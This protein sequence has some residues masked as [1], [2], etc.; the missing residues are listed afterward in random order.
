MGTATVLYIPAAPFE[1]WLTETF[2][3]VPAG[4]EGSYLDRGAIVAELLRRG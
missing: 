1:D 4:T 2:Q 3:A